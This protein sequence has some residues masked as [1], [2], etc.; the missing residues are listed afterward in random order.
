MT[1]S[2]PDQESSGIVADVE[3]DPVCGSRRAAAVFGL[4]APFEQ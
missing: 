1:T 4:A 2:S 3:G